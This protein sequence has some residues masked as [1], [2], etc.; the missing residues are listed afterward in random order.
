MLEDAQACT[1]CG[2]IW[3]VASAADI[4]IVLCWHGTI[5]GS[6]ISKN[7]CSWALRQLEDRFIE[8]LLLGLAAARGQ[9]SAVK[10]ILPYHAT[11]SLFI[12]DV[13]LGPCLA[14]SN[15]INRFRPTTN[16]KIDNCL[17]RWDGESFNST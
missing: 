12:H 14:S 5:A 4:P 7:C 2:S 17:S 6:G 13:H 3:A 15:F 10:G 11:W 9:I 16:Q 8:L 1:C